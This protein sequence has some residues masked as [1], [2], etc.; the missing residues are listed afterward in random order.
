ME[1]G[2]TR[3]TETFPR[4]NRYQLLKVE[5]RVKMDQGPLKKTGCGCTE[6][7]RQ[8]QQGYGFRVFLK[9]RTNRR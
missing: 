7:G 2:E 4:A 5:L 8:K 1:L 6:E 9:N 3:K